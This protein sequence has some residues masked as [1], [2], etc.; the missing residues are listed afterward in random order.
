[1]NR[2]IRRHSDASYLKYLKPSALAK[3]RDSQ[4]NARSHLVISKHRT[5]SLPSS[6]LR[7]L[8]PQFTSDIIPCFAGRIYG[9]RCP[10]RKKLVAAKAFYLP[11]TSPV[12]DSPDPILDLFTSDFFMVVNDAMDEDGN[13]EVDYMEF[14]EFMRDEGHNYYVNTNLF[15]RLDRDDYGS[16]DFWD[17]T[18]LCVIKSGRPFCRGCDEFLTS[19]Y[20]ACVKCF[21]S[22]RGPYCICLQ[23][24]DTDY[25]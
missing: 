12:L 2:R 8:T 18:T 11:P 4:I 6:P 23:C 3:L 20:F 5:Q 1:M 22:S 19:T 10:Q 17:V 14:N 16:L 24:Y 25:D 13:G 15:Q 7:P 21:E 9:V